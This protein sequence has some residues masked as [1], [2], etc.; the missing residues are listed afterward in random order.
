MPPGELLVV[1]GGDG[2]V[3]EADAGTIAI[4]AGRVLIMC[5]SGLIEDPKLEIGVSRLLRLLSAD[6]SR[7]RR[8]I[9]R[10]RT[11]RAHF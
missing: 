2:S 11:I 5:R 8:S 9:V 4:E 7:R 6:D 3:N 10:M 1:V